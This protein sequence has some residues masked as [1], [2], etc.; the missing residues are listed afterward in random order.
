MKFRE[1]IR[2]FVFYNFI[3]FHKGQCIRRL[4][5]LWVLGIP[6]CL[7]SPQNLPWT[8]L[9]ILLNLSASII[10]VATTMRRDLSVTSRFICDGTFWCATA[11]IL[12][13]TAY[14][15]ISLTCRQN[16]L[17]LFI[18]LVALIV[19]TT[20]LLYVVY[21]KIKCGKYN[22]EKER[23]IVF[24]PAVASASGFIVAGVFLRNMT[25]GELIWIVY[26]LLVMFSL[27]LF[28]I[29][30]VSFLKAYYAAKL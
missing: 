17:L 25:Q 27:L 14:K 4:I 3:P 28:S 19:C 7:I 21:N 26:Y 10:L 2:A 29:G 30:S 8:A 5:L 16:F 20:I 24:S 23:G 13:L 9:F 15:I 12:N 18:P 11:M 1:N 6:L 22:T